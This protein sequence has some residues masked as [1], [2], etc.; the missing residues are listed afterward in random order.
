MT[1]VDKLHQ[2]ITYLSD[3]VEKQKQENR[4]LQN[5]IWDL[6][7]KVEEL[8]EELLIQKTDKDGYISIEDYISI[9][10]L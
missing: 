1:K 3:L 9:R 8:E 2:E 7:T 5:E 6:M 4:E 10:D